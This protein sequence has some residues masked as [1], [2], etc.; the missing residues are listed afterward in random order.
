MLQVERIDM[1]PLSF[2]DC[3]NLMKEKGFEKHSEL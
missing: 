3:H 1:M 2:D